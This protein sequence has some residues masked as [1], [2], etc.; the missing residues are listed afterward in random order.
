MRVRNLAAEADSKD[1]DDA[2]KAQITRMLEA[3]N[4]CAMVVGMSFNDQELLKLQG[5]FN[6]KVGALSRKWDV[7]GIRQRHRQG[8]Q[9]PPTAK[10]NEK[11]P[12]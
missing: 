11:P 7:P 3:L 6:H 1:E 10:A 2:H 4:V 9:Q 12:V 8:S 5:D